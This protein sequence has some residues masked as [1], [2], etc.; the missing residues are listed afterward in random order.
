MILLLIPY[1]LSFFADLNSLP[2]IVRILLF[3]IPFS[4][5]FIASQNLIFGNTL[6]VI[7]GIVYMAIF[8]VICLIIAT[9]IFSSDRILTAKI[10]IKRGFVKSR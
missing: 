2:L 1:F 3:L 6:P 7:Y 9:K 4:H 10:K 5:P 8:F